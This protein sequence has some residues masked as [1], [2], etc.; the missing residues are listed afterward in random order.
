MPMPKQGRLK[1]SFVDDEELTEN[2]Y[3]IINSLGKT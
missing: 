3:Y 1:K 2:L